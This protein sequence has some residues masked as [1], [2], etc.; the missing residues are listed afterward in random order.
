M[1]DYFV[2]ATVQ[3]YNFTEHNE[4]SPPEITLDTDQSLLDKLQEDM[5]LSRQLTVE[6]E[7]MIQERVDSV[8]DSLVDDQTLSK[9]NI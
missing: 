4:N 3:F 6:M 2:L 7:S 5:E 9:W 8:L 1:I